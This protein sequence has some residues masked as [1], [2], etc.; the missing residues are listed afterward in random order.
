ML[1][2]RHT[3]DLVT[4]RPI[5]SPAGGRRQQ[6]WGVAA[7][8]RGQRLPEIAH[9]HPAQVENG[10]QGIQAARPPGPARQEGRR[11][12]D[13]IRRCLANTSVAQLDPLHRDRADAGLHLALRAVAMPNQAL[14]PVRQPNLPH[15]G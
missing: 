14:A 5:G 13:A 9:R 1:A 3:R 7:E 10:Q 2:M 11:E 15:G 4:Y 6:V 12:A 8:Q